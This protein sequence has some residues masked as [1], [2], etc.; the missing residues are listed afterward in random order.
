MVFKL[1]DFQEFWNISLNCEISNERQNNPK[2]AISKYI[3]NCYDG[4]KEMLE[5]DL[6][7]R[8][9]TR[10]PTQL[11]RNSLKEH[12]G[13]H[14]MASETFILTALKV[15]QIATWIF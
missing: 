5:N 4:L 9:K 15:A 3:S 8:G 1:S 10:N 7:F 2:Q 6:L 11:A 12:F 14:F 13:K